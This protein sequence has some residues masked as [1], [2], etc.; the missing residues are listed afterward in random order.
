MFLLLAFFLPETARNVVGNGSI[1]EKRWNQPLWKTFHRQ[2]RLKIEQPSHS[3]GVAQ[4]KLNWKTPLASIFVLFHPDTCLIILVGAGYYSLWYCIQAS[5]PHIYGSIYGF[6]E[7]QIGL[8]Y[9]PGAVAVVLGMYLSGRGV[10]YNYKRTARKL[11]ILVEKNKKT[12]LSSFPVERARTIWCTRMLLLSFGI[13]VG[14]G[15]SIVRRVHVSVPLIFQFIQG[16]LNC[17]ITQCYSVLLV[18][19]TRRRRA[20]Q[21]WRAT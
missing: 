20:R 1:P 12:D 8:A 18:D 11:G 21:V 4:H 15:W 19:G 16:F 2:Q 7:I 5:I 6:N 10:D 17:Y 9:I 13:M 3:T 14:Y